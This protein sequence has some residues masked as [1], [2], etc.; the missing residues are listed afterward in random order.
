MNTACWKLVMRNMVLP[1]VALAALIAALI[2][3][4][5]YCFHCR[6]KFTP[7]AITEFADNMLCNTRCQG[8]VTP[9][10]L[11]T[12][13]S[14]MSSC[15]I[16]CCSTCKLKAG[17]LLSVVKRNINH[18]GCAEQQSAL[19]TLALQVLAYG[20]CHIWEEIDA[21]SPQAAFPVCLLQIC[22]FEQ[23]NV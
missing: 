16:K 17:I 11:E 14:H 13:Y 8:R 15:I 3:V 1:Y 18:C 4:E 22:A 21:V 19:N 12:G 2:T 7:A 6:L 20:V 5:Q 23:T 9:L 10:Q